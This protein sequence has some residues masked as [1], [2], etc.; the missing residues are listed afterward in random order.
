MMTHMMT[1]HDVRRLQEE[2]RPDKD[3]D[4]DDDLHLGLDAAQI[5]S[6]PELSNLE[7]AMLWAKHEIQKRKITLDSGQYKMVSSAI[8]SFEVVE[9]TERQA[10]FRYIFALCLSN[11]DND[12]P[13]GK[14]AA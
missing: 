13:P 4:T 6:S 12:P 7:K 3:E 8:D 10:Y 5:K 11:S 2:N 1:E 14:I 9:H